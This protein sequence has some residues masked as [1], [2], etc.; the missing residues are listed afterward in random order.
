MKKV[1][2]RSKNKM[3]SKVSYLT[4]KQFTMLTPIFTRYFSTSSSL[5]KDPKDKSTKPQN[6]HARAKKDRQ[7]KPGDHKAHLEQAQERH[8][9]RRNRIKR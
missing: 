7:H 1:D 5:W 9:E 3:L 4:R 6:R 8:D 2:Q